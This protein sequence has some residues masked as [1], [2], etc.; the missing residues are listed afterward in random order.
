V[1]AEGQATVKK[2]EKKY[3]SNPL[4]LPAT[5][6]WPKKNKKSLLGILKD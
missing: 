3:N 5:V 1:A 4:G 2:K 6:G